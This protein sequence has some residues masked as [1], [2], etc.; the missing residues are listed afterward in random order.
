MKIIEDFSRVGVIISPL[1]VVVYGVN[2]YKP[3][4]L[5]AL[6]LSSLLLCYLFYLFIKYNL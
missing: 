6:T 4:A 2:N 1:L 3:I 5:V